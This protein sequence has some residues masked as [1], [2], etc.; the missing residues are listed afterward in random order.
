MPA[1]ISASL[2]LAEMEASLHEML[3]DGPAKSLSPVQLHVLAALYEKD[4]QR[5]S[6]LAEA[7]CRAATSFTPVLDSIEQLALVKRTPSNNDRRAVIISLTVK[8]RAL[9]EPIMKALNALDGWYAETDWT[10][11]VE[12]TSKSATV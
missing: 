3:K 9:R 2:M 5:P 8:G 6:D 1:W 12:L 7:A 10:P 11:D 4:N